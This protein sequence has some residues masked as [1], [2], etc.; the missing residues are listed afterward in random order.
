MERPPEHEAVEA[1]Q[2]GGGLGAAPDRLADVK[3]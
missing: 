3:Q 2:C 1:V